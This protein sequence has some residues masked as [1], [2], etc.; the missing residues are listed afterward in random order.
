MNFKLYEFIGKRLRPVELALFVKWVLRIKRRVFHMPDNSKFYIDPISEFGLTLMK[1]H[2][3]EVEMS[4]QIRKV[5]K[6]G[7]TFIDLGANEGYFS[8]IGS[9]IV[10]VEGTVISIEPQGR[11]WNII[12]KN[13]EVNGFSNV[14][15]LPYGIGSNSGEAV[16]NLYPTLNSGASTVAASFDF[17]V[18]FK[19]IRK[20]AYRSE[21]ITIKTLDQVIS[22]VKEVKLIKIDIEGFEFES[23]NGAIGLLE[24]GVF[25]NILIELHHESLASMQQNAGMID[26]L[27]IKYG[28][29]KNEINKNLVLY[30]IKS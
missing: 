2:D 30:S 24:K 9:R 27:L 1:N 14:K 19:G 28:Y 6:K 21:K 7:D 29:F 22:S 4:D 25:K 26:D 5:L 16:I 18:S 23:L 17:K 10:G 13:I 11:L 15:L 20:S 8:I 3:Y 12:I